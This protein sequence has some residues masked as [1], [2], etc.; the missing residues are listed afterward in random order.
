MLSYLNSY[1]PL[2]Y[3]VDDAQ[4]LIV[5]HCLEADYE[6]LLLW[7]HDVCPMPDFTVRLDRYMSD[8]RTPIV[9]GLYFTR[10][11]PSDPLVYRG[12]GTGAYRN[13]Q[14]GDLVYA[15]GV[16]TGLLLVHH[17]VLREM[18]KDSEEYQVRG[19]TT[20]RVFETPRRAW[21]DP[22]SGQYN[23]VSGTSDLEWCKRV[24]EGDYLRKAGWGAYVD[25]LP[26]KRFP[27]LVDTNLYARHINP[28][29]TVFPTHNPYVTPSVPLATA[30]QDE[31]EPLPLG[32]A[33]A[34]V[35]DSEERLA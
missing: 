19:V 5:K 4:N 15:D 10:G 16:P 11:W 7:E 28:D 12:R 22:A 26:D 9:S 18:W 13:W 6:W 8:E 31:D 1:M 29:G 33:V 21:Y 2:R 14:M 25:N 34:E 30:A 23:T 17:A 24:I 3:Q 20:R 27:F 35:I 32:V